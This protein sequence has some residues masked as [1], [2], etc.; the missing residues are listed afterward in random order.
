L[1]N[2][3]FI[4]NFNITVMKKFINQIIILATIL[5]IVVVSLTG[6]IYF[7]QSQASFELPP[8]RHILILGDSHTQSAINDDIYQRAA[9]VAQYSAMHLYSYCKLKKF[10]NENRHIDTV[11]LSFH[12]GTLRSGVENRWENSTFQKVP[13]YL[14]LFSWEDIDVFSSKKKNLLKS[15]FHPP[16]MLVLKFV[17]KGG[18]ISYKDLDIG[19]YSWS[20]RNRLQED[21]AIQQEKQTEE[22][23]IWFYQKEYLLKIVD[24]CKS[25][26]IEL[27]L[28]NTPTY[29][30][31]IYGDLDKLNDFHN[32]YLPEIKYWDYSAFPLPDDC[33]GDI[34]H[35]NYKGA[36]I[37]SK[38]LQK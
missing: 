15:V 24:L 16:Y 7:I 33:Y 1:Q 10:L 14:T 38:Y 20:N 31:E 4:F 5:T 35:L 25:R 32:A 27:I 3:L 13:L 12:Y 29:K 17:I 9:N 18:R 21:I 19:G 26:N 6:G 11:L 34:G 23:G 30:P 8:D 37:F 36:E 22:E 2:S 28:I